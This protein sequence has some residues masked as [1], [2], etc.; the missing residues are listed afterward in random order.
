MAK[1][2]IY[3]N[4]RSNGEI[5]PTCTNH[6]WEKTGFKEDVGGLQILSH[7]KRAAHFGLLNGWP[8]D[9]TP[10]LWWKWRLTEQTYYWLCQNHL[11]TTPLSHT[12]QTQTT[13]CILW[14][15]Y[16][17]VC[18]INE[19]Q[20][21][22]AFKIHLVG[23]GWHSLNEL[24]AATKTYSREGLHFKTRSPR[25]QA[26]SEMDLPET[27]KMKASFILK[28]RNGGVLPILTQSKPIMANIPKKKLWAP[29][30]VN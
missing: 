1:Q 25:D 6:R 30:R 15:H 28:V 22:F 2:L 26:T 20:I 13:P 12:S 8:T 11:L 5:M 7:T 14:M 10:D 3:T 27:A 23:T 4:M 24:Y 29:C 18:S 16:R 21:F 19:E 17:R 9:S